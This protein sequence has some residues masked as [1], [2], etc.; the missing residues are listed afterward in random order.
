MKHH[1]PFIAS[2]LGCCLLNAAGVTVQAQE[3]ADDLAAHGREALAAGRNEEALELFDDAFPLAT[4]RATRDRLL[5][6]RAVTYQRLAEVAEGDSRQDLLQR[7]E[8]LY[9]AYL[10]ANPDSGSAANNLAMV[11]AA[12]GW[13]DTAAELFERALALQDDKQGLYLK[14]YA[15]FLDDAGKWEE[16]KEVY[17]RMVQE[18]PLSPALQKS[19]A[20][21]FGE[22]GI[23]QYAGL[24][25]QLLETGYA[26]QAADNALDALETGDGSKNDRAELLTIVCVALSRAPYTPDRFADL[27]LT[28]ALR[29][30][31]SDPEIGPGAADIIRVHN[32]EKLDPRYYEWWAYR[33]HPDED[34]VRGV[35]PA[36]GFRALIRSLGSRYRQL[37]EPGLAE[38][39]YRL[40]ANLEPHEVDPAAIRDLTQLYIEENQLPK[41]NRLAAEYEDRLFEAKGGAYRN[42]RLRKIFEFHR[43]LGELYATIGR[44]GDSS[45]I[46]SAIF[47]LEHAQEKSREIEHR[48]AGTPPAEYRFSPDMVNMLATGYVATGQTSRSYDLRID[49]AER[50]QQQGDERAVRKV[51]EPIKSDDLPSQLRSRIEQLTISPAALATTSSTSTTS[52]PSR[53]G[54]TTVATATTAAATGRSMASQQ[55]TADLPR[56]ASLP[57]VRIHASLKRAR[58]PLSQ[59]QLD[60]VAAQLQKNLHQNLTNPQTFDWGDAP[61]TPEG[62]SIDGGSGV[63]ILHFAG[64]VLEI[65]FTLVSEDIPVVPR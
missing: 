43:T 53:T 3:T 55:S 44:W 33:F 5:F 22:A 37:G 8:R 32:V 21:R 47:Q 24:L 52:R 49:E 34:P 10:E 25:W 48:A 26:R 6:Y 9:D 2:V 58:S 19:M 51:L 64:E 60:R 1:H 38:S 12:L 45:E 14:N 7:S 29:A 61:G 50:F 27:G 11:Y 56:R 41:V 17:S 15:E 28:E 16:A 30:I 65:P 20:E 39:Y 54:A 31:G 42:S 13:N 57:E 63:L 40:A 23:N 46:D 18:Q 59:E 35:W 4:D 36:D 62:I